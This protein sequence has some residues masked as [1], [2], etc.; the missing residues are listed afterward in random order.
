MSVSREDASEAGLRWV[1]DGS[2]G[3]RR[4][5]SGDA[6]AYTAPGG[7]R[8][9]DDAT[10]QRIR[11]LAVPPAWTDV[12][13]CPHANGHLQATGRD[14]RGRKQYRYHERWRAVRDANKYQ[15]LIDFARA[16][17]RVRRR[18]RRDLARRG[19]PRAKV[20]ATVVQLLELTLI[21]VGNEEY[22]RDNRS[23]GL[24]TLRDR[25]VHVRGAEVRFVFRGKSG[26]EREV[27]L[28]DR[29]IAAVVR[30]CDELPGRQLFQY[31]DG[32]GERHAV[33]SSDVNDYIRDAAGG[34]F[35][36]KDFRTWA[37]TVLAARALQE[38]ER[39]DAEAQAKRNVVAAIEAVA[40]RLGNTRA[41]CRRCYVHPAIVDAYLDGSMLDVLRGRAE[42]EMRS[43]LRTLSPEEAAVL[44][45]LQ[46][47]LRH[48]ARGRRRSVA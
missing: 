13:I 48:E 29:R 10:L 26:R 17:P 34:E 43:S 33:D 1:S 24:T 25:H 15:R 37:G 22:A 11:R 45:L 14:A 28:R 41:V 12:W 40:A 19:L 46:Q 44:A 8:I 39:V 23:F 5:R 21:R 27:S 47:R 32:S 18:V 31:V 6:F 4:H 16:L 3:I 36:A 9:E 2:P 7:A 35:T 30:R 20:L 42:R 38:M